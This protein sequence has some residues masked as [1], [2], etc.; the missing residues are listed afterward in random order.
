MIVLAHNVR[1]VLK[2]AFSPVGSLLA[3]SHGNRA[4][5]L[6]DFSR[7]RLLASTSLHAY[8][9]P[10]YRFHPTEPQICYS[11][12]HG[13][14]CLFDPLTPADQVICIGTGWSENLLLTRD[15]SR[16]LVYERGYCEFRLFDLSRGPN[17][18]VW[19][20]PV[21]SRGTWGIRLWFE[22]L[23]DEERFFVA[24]SHDN[25]R[26]R[27]AVRSLE[28]GE[29]LG[30]SRLPNRTVS[31]LALSP[32]GAR[33]AV[34]SEMSL[35]VYNVE[36]LKAAPRSIRNGNR[37]HFTG[38]AFHPSGR[39]LAATSNDATVKLYDTTTW[40]VARSFTWDI[41]RMRSVCF[42]PDGTLAAAG[43]DSGKVVVWDVD[44]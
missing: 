6:W 22:L 41:G 1:P 15:A 43:S 10:E 37:K 26:T 2:V 7:Q 31:G 14:V 42:S 3:A 17:A 34:L 12:E 38:V 13:E 16:L 19:T 35:F 33:A 25:T 21:Y 18:P 5:L 28:T 36:K 27:V 30:G 39:Y 29:L 11:S 8:G 20:V 4:V 32:D 44:V 24:E 23:P 9:Q 40:E